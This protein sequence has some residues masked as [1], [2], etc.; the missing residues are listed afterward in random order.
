MPKGLHTV[1]VD[2]RKGIQGLV[3]HLLSI[4]RT[5]IGFIGAEQASHQRRADYFKQAMRASGLRIAPRS[6]VFSDARLADAGYDAGKKLLASPAGKKLD[7]IMAGSDLIALGLL[8]ALKEADR[9]V[10]GQIAVTGY[11]D[12]PA[13]RLAVPSLTTV[14]QP[15]AGMARAAFGWILNPERHTRRRTVF[16]PELKFR[17]ST[18]IL[19]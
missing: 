11:D 2:D 13:A 14:R 9:S 7:A 15:V 8:R 12:I 4:G 17:E 16:A 3:A 6:I 1:E 19:G 5:R 10:P 18:R